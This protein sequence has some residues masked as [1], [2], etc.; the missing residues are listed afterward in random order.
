MRAQRNSVREDGA[1]QGN[2]LGRGQVGLV[3]RDQLRDLRGSLDRVDDRTHGL[4][5]GDRVGVRGVHDV[6][7]DVGLADLLQG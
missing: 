4:H 7:D 3:Q 6:Q 1:Q 5:L 2:L